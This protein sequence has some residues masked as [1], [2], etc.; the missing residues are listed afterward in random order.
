MYSPGR[1]PISTHTSLVG[2][3]ALCT[4]LH[5]Y[6]ASFLLTHPLWDV[7]DALCSIQVAGSTFLLTHPLWDVTAIA[8]EIDLEQTFLL[9]HP[10]WDVTKVGESFEND[11]LNFYS[12]IPCGM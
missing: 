7:T 11:G 1:L 4:V 5:S 9:T 3:D 10:L 8:P 6:S 2:C 12:H